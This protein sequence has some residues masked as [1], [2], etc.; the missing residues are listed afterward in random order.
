MQTTIAYK[1]IQQGGKKAS[2]NKTPA[3]SQEAHWLVSRLCLQFFHSLCVAVQS[4]AVEA[5]SSM[6]KVVTQTKRL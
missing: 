5:G 3:L 6:Q 2:P 1:K 4:A